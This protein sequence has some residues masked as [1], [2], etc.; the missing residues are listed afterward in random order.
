MSVSLSRIDGHAL[1]AERF[2]DAE[3]VRSRAKLTGLIGKAFRNLSSSVGDEVDRLDQ[4]VTAPHRRV[5]HLQVEEALDQIL[6]GVE[7]LLEGE[8]PDRLLVLRRRR[9][10]AGRLWPSAPRSRRCYWTLRNSGRRA[11]SFSSSTGPT[12]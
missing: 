9:P 6:V 1:L 11:S 12:V 8:T 4:E 2:Q 10:G 3:R 5:E 7:R